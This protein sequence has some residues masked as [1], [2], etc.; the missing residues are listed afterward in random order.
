M[1][2]Q[3]E[4]ILAGE[5]KF[6]AVCDLLKHVATCAVILLL[7]WKSIAM[8]TASLQAKPAT[9]TA[10]AKCLQEWHFMDVLLGLVTALSCSAWYIEYRRNN[11]LVI[12][13]GQLRH[14]IEAEDTVHTR[15]GL[16]KT[17]ATPKQ[18][19]RDTK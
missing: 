16:D 15:S 18:K 5:H 2:A 6:V 19:K 1:G 13:I 11:H 17:G 10:F 9:L 7:G 4:K 12:K 14:E 3:L 8:L